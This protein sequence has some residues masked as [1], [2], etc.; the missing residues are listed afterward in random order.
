MF[1]DS[2]S[3]NSRHAMTT[4]GITRNTLPSTPGTNSS[5]LKAATVVRTANVTGLAI[6]YA[7]SIAPRI[8]SP[9]SSWCR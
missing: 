5:G 6:S 1:N 3:E 7:P 9:C 2:S 8:P 4:S